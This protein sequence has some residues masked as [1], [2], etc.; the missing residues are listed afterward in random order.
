M[1][2]ITFI[3]FVI[4]RL[5]CI[6]P[7]THLVDHHAPLYYSLLTIMLSCTGKMDKS[8]N[9]L[10][11]S[12]FVVTNADNL[13][14]M[15]LDYPF[16]WCWYCRHIIILLHLMPYWLR[17]PYCISWRRFLASILINVQSPQPPFWT[18]GHLVVSIDID[19]MIKSTWS[20][21]ICLSWYIR[22]G[23]D[24]STWL[25][26]CCIQLFH[27]FY[28]IYAPRN[29]SRYILDSSKYVD[30]KGYQW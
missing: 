12:L 3:L 21:N 8:V 19:F 15:Q 26:W 25:V 6:L 16:F 30:K 1:S 28:A 27:I 13:F 24:R 5:S 10:Q 18:T 22:C 4:G 17:W 7:H 2:H 23:S 29:C 20:Y 11:T 14:N 9:Y